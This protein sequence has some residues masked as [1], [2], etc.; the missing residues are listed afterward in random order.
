MFKLEEISVCFYEY[1]GRNRIH[2]VLETCINRL[3]KLGVITVKDDYLYI[4]TQ[5]DEDGM[6]TYVNFKKEEEDE[7][8]IYV[9]ELCGYYYM[10][11]GDTGFLYPYGDDEEVDECRCM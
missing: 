11:L 5:T 9:F 1:I 10:D 6:M 2:A 4:N 8:L 7:P 3:E